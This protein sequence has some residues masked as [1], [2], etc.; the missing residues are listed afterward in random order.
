MPSH[1]APVQQTFAVENVRFDV[2]PDGENATIWFDLT[3]QRFAEPEAMT[4]FFLDLDDFLDDLQANAPTVFPAFP[5][6]KKPQHA[7][8]LDQLNA[9][10]INWPDSL[11]GYVCRQMDIQQ[12][13][14]ERVG[15]LVERRAR[16]ADPA[17]ARL[18]A[19]AQDT[20]PSWDEVANRLLDG[21]NDAVV[22]LFPEL[23]TTTEEGTG[24]QLREM[25]EF[26]MHR[27]ANE[28]VGLV[29]QSRRAVPQPA[30]A[31]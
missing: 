10:Y 26:H 12:V 21:M 2:E 24:H 31:V 8:V 28:V 1:D 18:S 6:R 5:G 13:E 23:E 9:K 17:W 30:D 29:E 11:H 19:D 4:N 16:T 20:D 3:G 7:L 27:L 15:W 22:E 25:L 14:N